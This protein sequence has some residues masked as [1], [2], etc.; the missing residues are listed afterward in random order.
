MER[1]LFLDTNALLNL[2]ENAFKE[3]FVI[4]Q[5]TL[6]ELENIKSSGSKDGEVKYKARKVT[7][8]L[9]DNWGKYHVVK[10]SPDIDQTIESF[11]LDKTPDNIILA[12][13]NLN[14]VLLLQAD[15]INTLDVVSANAL[16]VTEA[17]KKTDWLFLL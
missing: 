7:R 12:T 16:I 15:E 5:K 13:R 3:E 4:A 11:N 2:Q 17:N 14:N 10:Y 1:K 6:E 8:L 9:D